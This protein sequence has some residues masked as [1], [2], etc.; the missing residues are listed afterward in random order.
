MWGRIL[1]GT[2]MKLTHIFRYILWRIGDING[3]HNLCTNHIHHTFLYT[4]PGTLILSVTFLVRS[5]VSLQYLNTAISLEFF[6]NLLNSQN[7]NTILT[8]MFEDVTY[9]SLYYYSLSITLAYA[10]GPVGEGV[11]PVN[12]THCNNFCT[13]FDVGPAFVCSRR[14]TSA[15]AMVQLIEFIIYTNIQYN[16]SG[17]F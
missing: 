11:F 15:L 9:L 4:V 10:A 3:I 8:K 2:H 5:N 14:P 16:P 12:T 17:I 6:C 1:Y 7:N 13:M